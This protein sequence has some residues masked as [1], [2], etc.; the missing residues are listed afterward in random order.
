M[1]DHSSPQPPSRSHG[2]TSLVFNLWLP[3]SCA[4]FMSYA[5]RNINAVLAPELTHDFSLSASELGMLTSAFSLA[6]SLA[7]LPGGVMMDRYGARRVNASLLM[8]AAVGCGLFST[9]SSLTDLVVGRALF[10]V[11]MSMCLMASIKTFS[12]WFSIQRLPFATG[13]LLA[14]GGVGGMLAGAPVGWVLQFV[15]WRTIFLVSGLMLSAASLYI[16][17]AVPERPHAATRQSLGVLVRGFGAI[18]ANRTFWRVN[19]M[20]AMTGAAYQ[21]MQSLWIGPWM[22]DVA[23]YDRGAVVTMISWLALATTVGFAGMGTVVNQ[24]MKRGWAPLL[25]FKLHGGLFILLFGSIVVFGAGADWVWLVL[26]TL[27]TGGVMM[28]TI[29]AQT[30]PQEWSGRVNTAA[31]VCGFLGTFGV[32]WGVGVVLDRYPVIDGHYDPQA[33]HNALAAMLVLLVAAYMWILPM[34]RPEGFVAAETAAG[35]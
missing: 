20:A 1:S 31:N 14:V 33:Y 35:K 4:Y 34:K 13:M 2:S 6:F 11:G 26:F 17:L 21:G 9:G 27:G 7:Q 10:G 8:L 30:F 16:F 19:L 12:Q 5:L 15:T 28:F 24:L 32:Q 3:F 22:R 25:L 29:Y 18:V 23:G